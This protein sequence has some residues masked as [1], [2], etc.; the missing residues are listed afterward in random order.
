MAPQK[1]LEGKVAI[2]TGSSVGIGEGIALMFAKEG[3]HVSITGRNQSALDKVAA[4]CKELGAKVVSTTG[5]LT[6]DVFRKKLIDNTL[7]TFGR[8]DVLV[9]NAGMYTTRS[10]ILEPDYDGFDRMHNVNLRSVYHLTGLA[11]PHLV[12]T[13]GNI[14]NISSVAGLRGGPGAI[15]Y[16]VSKAGLDMLTRCLAAEL[17]PHQVRVNGVNPGV[18]RTE[19]HREEKP[20][21]EQED[22]RLAIMGKVHA[23]GRIG[24]IDEVAKFVTFLASDDASFMTGINTPCDGGLL[25]NI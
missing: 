1:R 20:T 21:K 18:F 17:A 22:K 6:S 14:V 12:K 9:N 15:G 8:I 23:L 5:D 7:S 13:K 16:C 3:A 4:E 24:E 2:I 25:V 10:T 11:A 19:L